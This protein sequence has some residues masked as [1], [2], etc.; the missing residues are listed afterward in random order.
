[1][2]SIRNNEGDMKRCRV[3]SGAVG[4]KYKILAGVAHVI[5]STG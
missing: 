5:N 3:S 2:G 4:E 1:M